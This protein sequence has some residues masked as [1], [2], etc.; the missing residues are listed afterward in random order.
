MYNRQE[1]IIWVIQDEK[2]LKL[3]LS[4]DLSGSFGLESFRSLLHTLEKPIRAP[5]A[6]ATRLGIFTVP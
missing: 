1:A 3:Q 2:Y 6:L 5:T 4:G